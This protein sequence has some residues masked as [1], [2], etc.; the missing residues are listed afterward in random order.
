[1]TTAYPT[2]PL[3]EATCGLALTVE[4]GR[5]TAVR[6]DAE[7][8]FSKGF[9]CPKGAA[10]PDLHA[11]PDRL[12]TP[13]V[14]QGGELRPATWDEALAT[15][16]RGLAPLLRGSRDAVALYLGN[17]NVHTLA[18]QL[19]MKALV[20][21]LRTKS[22]YTASTLD[23]MPK[24]VASGLLFGD[25]DLIPVPDLDR[26]DLL[27]ILG[28]NPLASN[29]S[30]CTAPDFPGRLR[31]LRERGGRL[32]VVDP[33]RT[34]TA[35]IADVHLQVRPGGDPWLL[36]ALAEHLVAHDL[37]RPGLLAEHVVGLDAVREAVRRFPAERVAD[38]VGVPAGAIRGLADDLARAPSAAV[39]GRLGTHTARFGTL[40]A[41]LVEVVNTLTGNLDRPGG[42]MFPAP[43]HEPARP[44]RAP[45]GRG[46][47]MGR[48]TSRVGGHPEVRRELPVAALPDEILTPGEGRVRALIT[49][50][51]NPALSA[52]GAERFDRALA[53]LDF[54]VS[55]DP[56]LNETTR[57]ADVILPP[58]SP[59]ERAHCDLAF[60]G[61]SVRNVACYSPPTLP[62]PAGARA[63]HEILLSLTAI[64]AGRPAATPTAATDDFIAAALVHGEVGDTTSPLHGRAASELLAA[65]APRRGPERLID[66]L[67]RA[68]RYGDHFGARPGGLTFDELAAAPHGIDLGPLQPRLPERL[69]TP[70]GKVELAPPQLLAEL[71]RLEAEPTRDEPGALRLIGRRH[72]RS[73]NSWMHNLERLA[74][75]R[76]RC[77]LQVHPEDA[78]T[79]GLTDG[80]R[81]RVT[82]EAGELLVEVHITD[83]VRPGVV[84]LPHGWGHGQ[85]DTQLRVAAR[86]AGVNANRLVDPTVLDPLSGNAVQND[87]PVRVRPV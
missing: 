9:L 8:V 87:V 29:G 81:A 31:A 44:G 37:D 86:F 53:D 13:L 58:E 50:A 64:C 11:D 36:L 76:A 72:L 32:V 12:R 85:P 63:E 60:A 71:D 21:A 24:H 18:G 39:Y 65:L 23:Q 59:L 40:N 41:W 46:F 7:H 2:C 73:N 20:R 84:S 33:R 49:V 77:A 45:G 43:F 25:P 22:F 28:A 51:G 5:V 6:G 26:T 74:T 34:R 75:G 56:Y 66:F 47:Q 55:V 15:V 14:R 67:V 19:Y 83:V 68:G 16:E 62:L 4:G 70:S 42:A 69:R 78:A 54:M 30:L 1:M 10:L 3:C 82:S 52:P 35:A 57:H 27:V 48:W 79:L 80:G 38:R 61:L 17:P